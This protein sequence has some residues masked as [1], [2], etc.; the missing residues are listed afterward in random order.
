MSKE[1]IPA[2]GVLFRNYFVYVEISRG[3]G[4]SVHI[5]RH[6]I[7]CVKLFLVKKLIEVSLF[8]RDF[9]M[10]TKL[11]VYCCAEV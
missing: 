1:W 2:F 6:T 4:V 7:S 9:Q 5:L 8:K 11:E 10:V 3:S